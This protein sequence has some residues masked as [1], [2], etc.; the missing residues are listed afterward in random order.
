MDFITSSGPY[1][2]MWTVSFIRPYQDEV[3]LRSLAHCVRAINRELWGTRWFKNSKG[4]SGLV[5]AEPHR[6]SLSMR[7]RLH[8]HILLRRPEGI[9]RAMLYEVL[10]QAPMKL[11]DAFGKP[12]TANNRID[13]REIWEV[14]CLA[15]YLTKELRTSEWAAGDNIFFVEPSGIEGCVLSMRAGSTLKRRH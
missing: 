5:V 12:M 9:D 13:C 15:G 1:A 4:L 11:N 10:N 6:I 14:E 8:F 2:D 7:G 3:A